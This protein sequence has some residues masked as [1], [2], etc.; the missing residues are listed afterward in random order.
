MPLNFSASITF[1]QS[2]SMID[3]DSASST[4]LYA[5]ISSLADVPIKQGISVTGS[6]N[7]NGE[8]QPIGGVNQKIEGFYKVCKEKGLNGEQGVLIPRSNM[9]NLMLDEELVKAVRDGKFNIWAIDKIEDGLKILTG[10]QTGTRQKNLKFNRH[11]LYGKVEEKLRIYAKRTT[12]FRKS[13]DS[14]SKTDK[15]SKSDNNEDQE[16]SENK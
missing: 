8:I 4:E 9:E 15:K 16:N 2:Y 14:E 13:F 6:V 7:Q 3:G 12:E 11:S 5:L 10:L 1:E